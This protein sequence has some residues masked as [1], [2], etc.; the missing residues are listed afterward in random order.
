MIFVTFFSFIAIASAIALLS[1]RKIELALPLASMSIIVILF[2]SGLA[3][4]LLI[5]LYLLWAISVAAMCFTVWKFITRF[6]STRDLII[7][8][9]LI[10]LATAFVIFVVWHRNDIVNTWDEMSQWAAAVKN[11]FILNKFACS[12][13]SNKAY[14]DYPPAV[15]L[16]HYFWQKTCGHYQDS[17]LYVSMNVLTV[18]FLIPALEK[19]SFKNLFRALTAAVV[20]LLIPYTLYPLVY[21]HLFVDPLMGIVFGWVLY[22]YFGNR[23]KFD[24]F[25]VV[26]ASLGIFVLPI[27]KLSGMIFAIIPTVLIFIDSLIANPPRE[28]LLSLLKVL[29]L[30]ISALMSKFLWTQMLL[31]NK[32]LDTWNFDGATEYIQKSLLPW[33]REGFINFYKAFFNYSVIKETSQTVYNLGPFEVSAFIWLLLLALFAIAILFLYKRKGKTFFTILFVGACLYIV[34]VSF[35]YMLSFGANEVS[36]LSSFS[37]YINSYLVAILLLC[38]ALLL[39][40]FASDKTSQVK[41]KYAAISIVLLSTHVPINETPLAWF[42]AKF[43]NSKISAY[44]RRIE[45]YDYLNQLNEYLPPNAVLHDFYGSISDSRYCLCPIKVPS[46]LWQSGDFEYF[47]TWAKQLGYTHV[48]FEGITGS[49]ETE[50]FKNKFGDVFLLGSEIK[51]FSLYE[52]VWQNDVPKLK[53]VVQFG[54]IFI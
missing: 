33:Q 10:V 25:T 13:L 7:R 3:D 18:S 36:I 11:S 51:D 23:E 16:F 50:E 45:Y 24:A 34:S 26:S 37:R 8:P 28:K 41:W 9:G 1:N 49:V 20:I 6:M 42:D 15:E 2:F 30:T 27:I 40:S 21:T 14:T 4:N 35:L 31:S 29:P 22:T 43:A 52:V 39:K 47:R 12:P 32:I 53:F 17:T 44:S 48:F 54:P 46:P 5:G 19:F 38:V